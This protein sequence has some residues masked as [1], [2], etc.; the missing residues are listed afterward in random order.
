MIEVKFFNIKLWHKARTKSNLSCGRLNNVESE[1]LF[2]FF[3][4]N[5]NFLCFFLTITFIGHFYEGGDFGILAYLAMWQTLGLNH[6]TFA[7]TVVGI[8]LPFLSF[9]KCEIFRFRA[10]I[11]SHQAR[12]WLI[13]LDQDWVS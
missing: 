6:I 9:V 1:E 10:S 8:S 2:F 13:V 3:E 5:Q 7:V 11:L 12:V 4:L